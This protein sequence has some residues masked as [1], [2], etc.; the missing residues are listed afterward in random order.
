MSVELWASALAELG[1]TCIERVEMN[2]NSM[3]EIQPAFEWCLHELEQLLLDDIMNLKNG[4]NNKSRKYRKK[5][6]M[7][8]IKKI[9]VPARRHERVP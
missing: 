6:K 8:K 9:L 3:D 5:N 4:S 7:S 1:A 2:K